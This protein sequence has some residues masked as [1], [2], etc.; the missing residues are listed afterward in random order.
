MEKV[1]ENS[2]I[3]RIEDVLLK[4]CPYTDDRLDLIDHGNR[5]EFDIHFY[6]SKDFTQ[7]YFVYGT[8]RAKV[9]VEREITADRVIELSEIEELIDYLKADHNY[10]Y[11]DEHDRNN[12]LSEFKFNIRWGGDESTK[13]INCSTIGLVLSFRGNPELEKKYLYF[14]NKKYF[15]SSDISIEK[16]YTEEVIKSYV[17]SLDKDGVMYLLNRMSEKDLKKLAISNIEQIANYVKEDTKV[18]QY[19]IEK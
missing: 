10:M 7:V 8:H 3:S 13:G 5:P 17:D 4:Y 16:E 15:N 9:A 1:E 18:K 19:F 11:F 2:L 12:K 6:F 14:I